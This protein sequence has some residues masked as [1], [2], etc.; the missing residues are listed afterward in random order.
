M[1]R[2]A[3]PIYEVTAVAQLK[4][5]LNTNEAYSYEYRIGNKPT[6]HRSTCRPAIFYFRARARAS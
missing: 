6:E 3:N 4:K 2:L 1:S 5:I